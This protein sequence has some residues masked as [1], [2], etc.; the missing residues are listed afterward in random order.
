[1]L[2]G[3]LGASFLLN[4]FIA[5]RVIRIDEVALKEEEKFCSLVLK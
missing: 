4:L 3:T 5:E 1:M 2:I